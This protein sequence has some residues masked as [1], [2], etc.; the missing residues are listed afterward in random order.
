MGIGNFD[1]QTQ[2]AIASQSRGPSDD[3]RFKPDFRCPTNS[4]TADSGGFSSYSG[5]GGTSGA[6]PYAGAAAALVRNFMRGNTGSIDPGKVYAFLINSGQ[7]PYPFNN[8]VGAGDLVLPV[9]GHAWWGKT[10]ITD[11]A[12]RDITINIT[13]PNYRTLDMAIWWPEENFEWSGFLPRWDHHDDVDLRMLNPS[14]STVSSSVSIPSV[15]ERVRTTGSIATGNWR[16]RIHGYDVT[17]T[18]TVYWCVT[19]TR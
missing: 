13:D 6:T 17:G 11:G 3:D 8:D 15:F 10:T 16:I 9:N 19:G 2:A 12:N 4:E 7:D 14:G 1:V 5:F 18:Q